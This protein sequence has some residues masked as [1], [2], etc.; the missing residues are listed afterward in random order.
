MKTK[1]ISDKS[2]NPQPCQLTSIKVG[3]PA[4]HA[5]Q[6]VKEYKDNNVSSCYL[7]IYSNHFSSPQLFNPTTTPPT[8]FSC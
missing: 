7:F 3:T 2:T 1:G 6:T 5:T 4:E 8:R